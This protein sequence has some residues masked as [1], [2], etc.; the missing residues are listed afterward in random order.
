MK[1]IQTLLATALLALAPQGAAL[2]GS[3]DPT[4]PDL[5]ATLLAETPVLA[6]NFNQLEANRPG[7]RNNAA[8]GPNG[9]LAPNYNGATA[10]RDSTTST[11]SHTAWSCGVS[12]QSAPP[13]P[14]PPS[15]EWNETGTWPNCQSNIGGI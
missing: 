2:G 10:R 8:M 11:G 4:A 9:S 3:L 13:P 15:C 6:W 1:I 5:A 7:A 14:P 12:C